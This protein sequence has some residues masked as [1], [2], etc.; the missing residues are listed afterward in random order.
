VTVDT[1][2][3]TSATESTPAVPDRTAAGREGLT[4]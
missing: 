2:P 4:P 3:V 1:A